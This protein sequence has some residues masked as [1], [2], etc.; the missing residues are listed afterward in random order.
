MLLDLILL[1]RFYLSLVAV[2]HTV[3]AVFVLATT[4]HYHPRQVLNGQ[5]LGLSR[6]RVVLL[7]VVS[8]ELIFVLQERILTYIVLLL[9]WKLLSNRSHNTLILA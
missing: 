7:S 9:L 2:V 4:H 8:G 3:D 6:L 5:T 1:L